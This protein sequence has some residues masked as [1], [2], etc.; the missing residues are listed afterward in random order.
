M[1]SRTMNFLLSS[2]FFFFLF[3]SGILV[4]PAG[5]FLA[6]MH[7]YLLYRFIVFIFRTNLP[8]FPYV[9]SRY[10]STY[11]HIEIDTNFTIFSLFSVYMCMHAWQSPHVE[12]R[13]QHAGVGPPL[14]QSRS[15]GWTHIVWHGN[16]CLYSISYLFACFY[17][18]LKIFSSE[19][20]CQPQLLYFFNICISIY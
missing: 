12:G 10:L 20:F 8:A 17:C 4:S 7:K 5:F 11:L 19:P 6:T 16:K 9:Y 18:F 14:A 15:W 3:K 2:L 13:E 1:A